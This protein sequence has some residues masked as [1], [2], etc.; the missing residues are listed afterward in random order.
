[1]KMVL[2]CIGICVCIG[3]FTQANLVIGTGSYLTGGNNAYI[4]LAGDL[5]TNG[6]V[7]TSST[8]NWN[9][10]GSVQQRIT[11]GSGTGCTAIYNTSTYPVTVGNVL[12]NNTNGIA[13]EVNT[14][15]QGTHTFNNGA[16]E[17]KEGVYWL[18]KTSGAYT[19]NSNSKF[20][21]TSGHGLLKQSSIT[22]GRLFPVGSSA[23][24][25]D[26]TPVTLTYA[27][28]ADNFAVRVMDNV[29]Y[30]YNT[31]NG[32]PVVA[33][34]TNT[35]FVKKTWIIKKDTRT[36]G[37]SF[38]PTLQWNAVNEDA[39][40]T[41]HR[42]TDVTIARNHDG[43]WF[44]NSQGSASGSN[45]YTLAGTVTYDNAGWEYYPISATAI[46][47]ILATTG[48]QLKGALSDGKV[49][50]QW[51]TVTE[52]NTNYFEV[53]RSINGNSFTS[54]GRVSAAGNSIS[55]KQ[56][57]Y[58]D[59]AIPAAT[60]LFYRLKQVDKD[61]QYKLSDILSI[62]ITGLQEAASV[63]PNPASDYVRIQSKLLAGE[64]EIQLCD[65]SGKPLQTNTTN[66]TTSGTF[67]LP[68]S[69]IAAGTYLLRLKA[70][71]THEQ[72]AYKITITH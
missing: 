17:I 66:F 29:Y 65:A 58:T 5:R 13:V 53:Q 1:M 54:I 70:R 63:Y 55:S 4:V 11:C 64:Y 19:G 39:A 45:P 52:T 30:S 48:L 34:T 43:F 50:L 27:G 47:T 10:N 16:T 67:Y 46:N 25:N 44:P 20:F 28:I 14:T 2:T 6:T 57:N 71:T 41:S 51:T 15:V 37:D 32:D 62:N 12:Q 21:V 72:F 61:N 22:T 49:N 31:T 18:T 40:F 36:T 59:G 9:F 3:G 8:S 33:S 35:R 7:L 69:G 23:A 42:F 56:Y 38:S 68:C 24:S 60:R 26:Y